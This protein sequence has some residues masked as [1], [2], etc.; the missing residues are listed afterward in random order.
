MLAAVFPAVLVPRRSWL[1][2]SRCQLIP[3]ADT[4]TTGVL[5]A[6]LPPGTFDPAAM[7]PAAVRLT[8]LI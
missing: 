6:A 3:L 7:K 1:A 8:T 5:A 2:P 4:K